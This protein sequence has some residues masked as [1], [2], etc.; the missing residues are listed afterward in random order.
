MYAKIFDQ[1][2][3]SSIADDCQVRWVFQDMLVLADKNGVVDM[4]HQAISRR[5]NVPLETVKRAIAALE[6]PDTLSRS[7][8]FDGSRIKRL[9]EHRD[10]GWFIVNVQKYR[11][12]ATDDNYRA[13]SR[14]RM[15]KHRDQEKERSKERELILNTD[16]DTDRGVTNSNGN[17]TLRNVTQPEVDKLPVEAERW[18]A[19][20]G[21]ISKVVTCGKERM[22]HIYA[23]RKEP[24][25]QLN[26]EAGLERIKNSLFCQGVSDRGWKASFDWLIE[27]SDVL[28]KVI[29]G[30]YDNRKTTGV[31]GR[32]ASGQ[33]G[34]DRNK[35]TLN[36]GLAERY[37]L[38]A[39]QANRGV[40]N[41]PGPT[42]GAD[43]GGNGAVRSEHQLCEPAVLADAQ[44]SNRSGKDSPGQ[45]GVSAVHGAKPV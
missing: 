5:T 7:T 42:T 8:E 1:I 35:G 20:C 4:T 32:G 12:I 6:A 33:R 14:E 9:D 26:F 16:T 21:G 36:E 11:D 15:R 18:N 22:K 19:V 45:G 37:D 2:F 27:Q 3:D 34:F 44:R 17:A 41:I 31:Q 39:V 29:E 10:W 28:A 13:K 23:R 24:F 38:K 40:R 25:W 43:V 30:K